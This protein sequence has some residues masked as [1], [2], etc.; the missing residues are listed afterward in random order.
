MRCCRI[1]SRRG[2]NSSAASSSR[3]A[4]AEQ[5]ASC[6]LLLL[7]KIRCR[8]P[9]KTL[10]NC[11]CPSANSAACNIHLLYRERVQQ[12][13][14]R[15]SGNLSSKRGKRK[16]HNLLQVRKKAIDTSFRNCTKS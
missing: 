13:M 15:T 3:V 10:S 4:K 9:V 14:L 1:T 8:R 5:A 12:V 7:S 11:T 6:T 16:A 2:A